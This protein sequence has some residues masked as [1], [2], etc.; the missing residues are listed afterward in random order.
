MTRDA[1]RVLR[2]TKE[3]VTTLDEWLTLFN[4]EP[5]ILEDLSVSNKC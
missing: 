3:T 4:L 2:N 5:K 1:F